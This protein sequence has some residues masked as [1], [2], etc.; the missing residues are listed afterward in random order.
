[1]GYRRMG[2]SQGDWKWVTEHSEHST[3]MPLTK[4]WGEQDS[5]T[6]EEPVE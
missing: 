5:V 3:E 4:K 1:M 2:F 6:L